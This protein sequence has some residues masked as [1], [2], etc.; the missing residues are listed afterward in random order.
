M[1]GINLVFTGFYAGMIME[2]EF[3]VVQGKLR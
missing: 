1:R 3:K 2:E